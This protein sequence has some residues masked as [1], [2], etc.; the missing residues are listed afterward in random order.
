MLNASSAKDFALDVL[1]G[2]EAWCFLEVMFFFPWFMVGLPVTTFFFIYH[3]SPWQF[4]D[5][6]RV[7]D[8]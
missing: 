6:L 1:N 8:P 5:L 7:R 2:T 3:L 4:C